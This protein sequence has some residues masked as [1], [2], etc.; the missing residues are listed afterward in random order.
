MALN[1]KDAAATV[2]TALALLVYFA[3]YRGWNVWLVGDSYRWAAGAIMLLGVATCALGQAGKDITKQATTLL[4]AGIGSLSLLFGVWT[5]LTGSLTAL[6]LLIATFVALW[7]G[8]TLRHAWRP[9][10][11]PAPA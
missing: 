3:S 1:R 10:H 9:T 6:S 4:L 8:S 11:G 2:L 7:A 5:L